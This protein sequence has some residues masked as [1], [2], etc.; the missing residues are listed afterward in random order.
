MSSL[1]LED[2]WRGTCFCYW[3]PQLHTVGCCQEGRVSCIQTK[4]T[5]V[6]SMWES[7]PRWNM[8]SLVC[9]YIYSSVKWKESVTFERGKK[10]PKSFLVLVLA[11]LMIYE[12]SQYFGHLMSW[13]IGKDPDAGKGRRRG[14]QKMRRLNGV[15]DSMDM[16]LSKLQETV[17]DK[18]A[19]SAAVHGVAKSQMWQRLNNNNDKKSLSRVSWSTDS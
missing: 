16:N 8:L 2:L 18:D 13:L 17:K 11:F 1:S 3:I 19:W 9:W 15:T 4:G 12:K 10:R 14:W 6:H 7:I 5:F